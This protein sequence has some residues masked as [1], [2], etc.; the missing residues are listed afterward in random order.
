MISTDR[1]DHDDRT[2]DRDRTDEPGPFDLGGADGAFDEYD[3]MGDDFERRLRLRRR[4][5]HRRARMTPDRGPRLS[6]AE[7]VQT[8]TDL[9]ESL[10]T[11][12]ETTYRPSKHER[13]WIYEALSGFYFQGDIT[14]VLR[15]VKGGK[16][17][18]VYQCV[19]GPS[20]RRQFVAAKIY[21][22]RRFRNLRNDARYRQ[23]RD[24]L[25]A[26]GK[27]L[28]D[29]R[30]A[31]AILKG[32]ARGKQLAHTS[33]LAHEL[34]ALQELHEAG[35]D[36]PQPLA[37][38]ENVILMDYL[39]DEG[40]PAPALS[41][42]SLALEEAHALFARVLENVE[43]MLAR[44]MV[45]GDLS[46]YNVLYHEGRIALIDF[47]QVVD[48]LR[49]PDA[50]AIFVRDVTRICDYFHTQGVAADA[51]R[52]AAEIWS[53]SLPG[54]PWSDP[55][56]LPSLLSSLEQRREER[57]WEAEWRREDADG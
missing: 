57:E 42:V 29:D 43:L 13:S 45:H 36:V 14:D 22:P 30:A 7:L 11:G 53:R 25:D 55:T 52:L 46:A 47:P 27:Q 28:K 4:D 41:Q 35:A 40:A 5:A 56:R 20:L 15:M 3:E 37:S 6:R 44:H 49:N 23:G 21:R 12:F 24:S 50:R 16:E 1:N 34:R 31:R 38:G 9:D 17:A 54:D 39:G 2:N 48:P 19:A 51:E 8:V 26:D 18:C 33:W 10:E 32:T